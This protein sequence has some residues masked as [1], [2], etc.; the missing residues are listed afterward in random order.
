MLLVMWWN[1]SM[2]LSSTIPS[3]LHH[4]SEIR[5]SDFHFHISKIS[6]PCRCTSHQ[7]FEWHRE[8]LLIQHLFFFVTIIQNFI[9]KTLYPVQLLSS[10]CSSY[11]LANTCVRFL[12][13]FLETRILRVLTPYRNSY[14]H[15]RLLITIASPCEF[16]EPV[17]I[18]WNSQLVWEQ[19]PLL[20]TPG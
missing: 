5:L 11:L 1:V 2:G 3:L 8:Q 4:R 16:T 18:M 7:P 13:Y 15:T 10:F 6:I 20:H 14:T 17:Q 12:Q 9:T 19:L